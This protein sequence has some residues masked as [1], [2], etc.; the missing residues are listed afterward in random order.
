LQCKRAGIKRVSF[1]G[2]E[3]FLA[4]DF[5]YRITELAVREGLLFGRIMTNG[6]W[7]KSAGGLEAVLTK[8]RDSGYDGDI[9]ASVD[10]FHAQAI[11]KIAVFIKTAVSVWRRPDIVSIAWVG[12][13]R[14]KETSIK[15]KKLLSGLKGMPVKTVRIALS[16]VSGASGLSDPWGDRWFKEDY[17]KGPGNALFVL[18]GGDVKPCCGYATDH[19]GLTIGNIKRDSAAKIIGAAGR[20]DFVRSVFTI[21]LSGIRKRLERSGIRFPGKAENH[22]FF[23]HYL[24]TKVPKAA[25]GRAVRALRAAVVWIALSAILAS[26][27]FADTPIMKKA[28]GYHDLPIKV[29]RKISIPKWYHEGLFID[30]DSMWVA[31]G[32][33]GDTWVVDIKSG[34]R[35]SSIESPA[36]FTEAIIKSGDDKYLITDWDDKRLYEASLKDAKFA[37]EK[38]LTDF[39]PSHPAGLVFAG[40][41]LLAIVWTRGMGTKFEIL[42][43]DKDFKVTER[44]HIKDIQ[45]PAH[46]AWDGRSLW[47]TGWYNRKVYRV[48]PKNWEITASFRAPVNKVT[49]ITWDGKYLWLTGTYADLYQ[50]E[51]STPGVDTGC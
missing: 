17:C 44:I 15:L 35:I 20:N 41:S 12:G 26:P 43:L 13:S 10:A 27:L 37:I 6:V 29:V 14:E 50:I 3:P 8:L 16:P 42:K 45:E 30:G 38:T 28:K 23:C 5:L 24:L 48:D 40:D 22:C 2:G 34:E 21:G 7:Y 31:N 11:K 49:G 25:L 47:I 51:V 4:P 19:A 36:G 1:T 32:R 39:S 33:K 46:M 18:P 9:C